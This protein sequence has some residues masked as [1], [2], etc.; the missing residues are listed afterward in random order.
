MRALR[1]RIA[2]AV[3][4]PAV[5]ASVPARAQ[6]V[7]Y[8]TVTKVELPGAAGTAMRMAARLG[9][10]S[11][12]TVE[13]TSIKGRKMRT[14]V[15]TTSTILDLEGKRF[16]WLDNAAKTYTV[17]TFDELLRRA[18]QTGAQ[19]G[20]ANRPAGGSNDAQASFDFRFSVDPGNAR[21]K[22]AGYDADRFFLTAEAEGE[23][24]PE[25]STEREKAGT[26]VVLS[27]MWTSKDVPVFQARSAFD[28]PSARQYADAGAAL[29]QGLAAAF[30]DDPRLK[31]AL[32]QS[33]SEARKIQ[34]M[35][36]RTVTTFVSVA[37][38]QRFDRALV[39]DPAAAQQGGGGAR[40]AGRAALGRLGGA[41]RGATQQQPAEPAAQ[42][43][44]GGQAAQPAQA[45][46]LTVTSEI[47][48]VRPGSLDAS[49]FDIPAGYR[50]LT[51]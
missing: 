40:Q 4:V 49:L 34:G 31:V 20:A 18:Q 6:D 32:Q 11:M 43:G 28:D 41:I 5:F 27:D 51:N 24:V 33:V 22:V 36:V 14:D 35:P 47:R 17:S 50:Q 44:Q 16:I 19:A 12:E 13:K 45:T 30:A 21:Q 10:G 25:G 15:G 38:G 2:V 26:L 29:M 3:A 48:N 42:G 8:E 9:G 1:F 37:P 46:I 23:Y 7:Q 39:T